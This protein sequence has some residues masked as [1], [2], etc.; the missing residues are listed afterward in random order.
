MKYNNL[1]KSYTCL[2]YFNHL[3][4][5][6]GIASFSCGLLCGIPVSVNGAPS[7]IDCNRSGLMFSYKL[8]VFS[9]IDD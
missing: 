2:S 3:G 8:V 6:L 4:A 1:N 7:L 9:M 5:I